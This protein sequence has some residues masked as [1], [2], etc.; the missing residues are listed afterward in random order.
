MRKLCKCYGE[1]DRWQR[2]HPQ[3][4]CHC[5]VHCDDP[6]NALLVRLSAGNCVQLHRTE[7]PTLSHLTE[8]GFSLSVGRHSSNIHVTTGDIATGVA[9]LPMLTLM[10]LVTSP[11]DMTMPSQDPTPLSFHSATFK[12][13]PSTS[14]LLAALFHLKHFYLHSR[15]EKVEERKAEGKLTASHSSGS[16]VTFHFYLIGW[17]C[18][19]WSLRASVDAGKCSFS[20]VHCH[21]KQILSRNK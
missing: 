1:G 7:Y 13:Q 6:L 18:I 10:L 20:Q 11:G 3:P 9:A 5:E 4:G 8:Q 12:D 19:T 16:S 14:C 17:N 15:Q 2:W 21:L